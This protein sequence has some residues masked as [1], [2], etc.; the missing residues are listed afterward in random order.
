MSSEK[1]TAPG[2]G[3]PMDFSP[4]TRARPFSAVM[5]FVDS[6]AA[7]AFS[8]AAVIAAPASSVL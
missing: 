5:S 2:S 7:V 1:E 3:V 6:A 4:S 8:A